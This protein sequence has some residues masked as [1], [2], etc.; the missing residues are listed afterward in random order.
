MPTSV[1]GARQ[2][3]GTARR[4]L[5]NHPKLTLR[6]RAK[7]TLRHVRF[8]SGVRLGML[9]LSPRFTGPQRK[10]LEFWICSMPLL[11]RSCLPR[12]KLAVADRLSLA[13]TSVFI[14]EYPVSGNPR[15]ENAASSSRTHAVSFIPE[16][17]VVL[18][19]ALFH[20]RVELGRILYHELCHF[21]WPRLGNPSR[22]KFAALLVRE[23]RQ[24]IAGELGYSAEWRKANLTAGEKGKRRKD[25]L[26]RPWREYVCESFCDTG[27][28]VLLDR[29]RR[30]NHSE[31]TLSGMARER[32]CSHWS[33][34]VLGGG[35]ASSAN[36]GGLAGSRGRRPEPLRSKVV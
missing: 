35:E 26:G 13:G 33:R 23:F 30:R 15:S 31:Y 17:Y 36:R 22:E 29:E 4:R 14:N 25:F 34:L 5:A 6:Q 3:G 10:K 27:S 21:L 32:R 2:P 28:F 12:L 24:G 19:A 11:F 16:R 9:E 18:D 1:A 7:A 20:R 8:S